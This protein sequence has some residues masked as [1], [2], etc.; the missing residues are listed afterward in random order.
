MRPIDADALFTA[1]NE[2]GIPYH[3]GINKIIRNMPTIEQKTQWIPVTWHE[4]TADDGICADRYPICLDCHMPDDGEEILVTDGCGTW[5]DICCCDDGY[6]LE[7][8]S[9]W[10]DI[11]AWMPMP[12]AYEEDENEND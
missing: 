4:T 7:S 5:S 1:L 8:G 11:K 9:N 10:L 2:S 3:A 6:Y 12:E